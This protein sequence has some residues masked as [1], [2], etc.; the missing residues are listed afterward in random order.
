MTVF[1]TGKFFQ[2]K[3]VAGTTKEKQVEGTMAG[4]LSILIPFLINALQNVF[5]TQ[6]SLRTDHFFIFFQPLIFAKLS[7]SSIRIELGT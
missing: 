1:E 2:D 6:L 7:I 5:S 4:V 3:E